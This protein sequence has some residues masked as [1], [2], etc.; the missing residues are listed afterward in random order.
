MAART[1]RPVFRVSGLSV[2]QPDEELLTWLKAV[3]NDNLT[4]EEKS[5]IDVKVAIVPS[6]Y[7]DKERVALTEYHGGVPEF[8][9]MLIADPLEDLSIEKGDTDITFD[10]H[11]F[12]FTQLYTPKANA[13]VSAE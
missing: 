13:P 5:K 12:G 9:S 6:C 11:F 10:C 2:L 7:E 1:R 3:I 8:L 4:E